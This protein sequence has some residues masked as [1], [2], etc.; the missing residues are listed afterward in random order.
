MQQLFRASQHVFNSLCSMQTCCLLCRLLSFRPAGKLP[1][2][3]CLYVQIFPGDRKQQYVNRLQIGP[4]RADLLADYQYKSPDRINVQFVDV[5][6]FVGG[7]KLLSKVSWRV[8]SCAQ[9]WVANLAVTGRPALSQQSETFL[10][11]LVPPAEVWE[12]VGGMV[13]DV[14]RQREA[15]DT[16]QQSGQHF[17]A[18]QGR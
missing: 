12:Q 1:D 11:S 7:L 16:P 4:L 3:T 2:S 5:T 8:Q 17:C 14:R 9:L 15:Q 13:A 10:T 18:G 6:L